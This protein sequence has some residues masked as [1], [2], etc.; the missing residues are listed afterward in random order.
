MNIT[1]KED[2]WHT[3]LFEADENFA[4]KPKRC[5]SCGSLLSHYYSGVIERLRKRELLHQDYDELCCYCYFVKE[6]L[7]F[8][9]CKECGDIIHAIVEDSYITFYCIS[10]RKVYK[11]DMVE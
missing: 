11:K 3:Y 1:K 2:M 9:K 5:E 4:V 8:S 6:E 7:G 10:C